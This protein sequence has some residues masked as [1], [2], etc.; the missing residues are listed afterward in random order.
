MFGRL[1]KKGGNFFRGLGKKARQAVDN[2]KTF[3]K[4]VMAGADE[5][6]VGDV[7]R[8]VGREAMDVGKEQLASAVGGKAAGAI[9]SGASAYAKGDR[10]FGQF[11]RGMAQRG[12]RS[13]GA[14][15]RDR[16]RSM[17]R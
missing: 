4:K 11:A 5:L 13:G 8:D 9:A 12:A 10:E 17:R 1:L 14:M 3:G 6:G 2:V 15:L 7:L 16:L